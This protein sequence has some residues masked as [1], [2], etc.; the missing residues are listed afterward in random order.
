MALFSPQDHEALNKATK[1]VNSIPS[2]DW[3]PQYGSVMLRSP[4]IGQQ[5][6]A[7]IGL[8]GWHSA[9]HM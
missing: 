3:F 9:N 2:E 8:D 7:L 6:L 1:L 5:Q 4:G